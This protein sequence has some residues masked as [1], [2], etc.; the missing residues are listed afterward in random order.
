MQN[1]G[2]AG[3][4]TFNS[5]SSETSERFSLCIPMG[6][7]CQAHVCFKQRGLGIINNKATILEKTL[8]FVLSG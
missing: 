8:G 3:V 6:G 2:L 4:V 1:R 7:V 5:R